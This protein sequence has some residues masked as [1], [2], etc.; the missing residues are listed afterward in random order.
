MVYGF[1]RMDTQ[2]AFRQAYDAA[3]KIKERQDVYCAEARK[4]RWHKLGEFPE[5]LQWESLVDVLRGRVKVNN[6]C[7]EA[8]DF[9]G[10]IRVRA[11]QY[12]RYPNYSFMFSAHQR[13]Q[14]LYRSLPSRPRGLSRPRP[15]QEDVRHPSGC[16]PFFHPRT[17]QAGSLPR[18]RVR[19][20]HSCGS[21]FP[22]CYEGLTTSSSNRSFITKQVPYSPITRS[23]TLDT[24]STRH[25]KHISTGC[26]RISPFPL[27][28]LPPQK[29][30]ALDIASAT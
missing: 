4:G 28:L 30:P 11:L 9:D 5:S 27:S 23:W 29:L 6:H 7:Y 1:T 25:S 16:R 3:R 8:V 18:V 15:P 26:R 21:G 2:W 17:L 19:A 24:S 10:M 20:S 22:S 12:P 13:V 14:I